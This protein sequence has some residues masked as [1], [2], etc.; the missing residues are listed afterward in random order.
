MMPSD[1]I[2]VDTHCHVHFQSFKDDMTEVVEKTVS[3][4]VVM[5]AVGTQRDTSRAGVELAQRYAHIYAS[6]GLHPV[7]LFSQHIDEEES[8][9]NTREEV[10]DYDYYRTLAL[11]PKTIAIGEC[12]LDLYR[13]PETISADQ[14]LER[15]QAVFRDHFRLAQEVN[16]PLAIHVRD[17]YPQMIDLLKEL[18]LQYNQAQLRSVI[19]CYI[20]NWEYAQEFLKLGS[21]LGFT[22][23]ITFPPKKSAPEAQAALL[24]VVKK[25]P[26]DR[27]VLETDSP[28]LAPGKFR[29]KRAEPWMVQEVAKKIAEIKGISLS[30]VEKAT[31]ENAL[32][33][34]SKIKITNS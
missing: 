31:T 5:N 30:D 23:I 16:L 25:C 21:Y 15:Q 32:K 14:V 6:V 29:G 17:A 12:G 4:G 2:F 20:G 19:H 34:F 11:N 13:L 26:L 7:H 27:M 9:F 18:M 8:S 3:Q 22:G 24:E 28:Y 1:P 33:L 10:F